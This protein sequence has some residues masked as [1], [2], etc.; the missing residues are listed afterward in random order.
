MTAQIIPFKIEPKH[1]EPKKYKGPH[2]YIIA[3][4]GSKNVKIGKAEDVSRRVREHQCGSADKL[5]IIRSLAG[6]RTVES[7]FHRHFRNERQ[8]GEWFRFCPDMM[9]FFPDGYCAADYGAKKISCNSSASES[10]SVWMV[11][12][13]SALTEEIDPYEMAKIDGYASNIPDSEWSN[14]ISSSLEYLI[15]KSINRMIMINPFASNE[16]AARRLCGIVMQVAI[17]MDIEE[18]NNTDNDEFYEV[19]KKNEIHH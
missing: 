7:A 17:Q 3:C 19:V 8:H 4:K 16:E 2:V 9:T 12:R 1:D 5:I 18:K 14:L 6:D 13:L 10:P 11:K 15:T